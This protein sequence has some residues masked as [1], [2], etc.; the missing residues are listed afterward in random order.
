[1]NFKFTLL[2]F[3]LFL[4]IAAG[5]QSASGPQ[6]IKGIWRGYFV[7]N[8]FGGYVED[9]YKFEV[10]IDQASN[11]ALKGVTYSYKT[12]VFYGKATLQGIYMVKTNNIILNETS[13]VELKMEGESLACLMT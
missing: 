7:Q 1:M 9:R 4:T 6:S 13:L 5:A 10:Q 8:S 11:N 2:N 3:L 12:T